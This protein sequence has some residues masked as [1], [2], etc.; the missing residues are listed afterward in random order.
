[1]NK[2]KA[3]TKRKTGEQSRTAGSLARCVSCITE[4]RILQLSNDLSEGIA[5][6]TVRDWRAVARYWRDKLDKAHNDINSIR[7]SVAAMVM[8]QN[9]VRFAHREMEEWLKR[10]SS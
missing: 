4:E 10:V 1:M 9:C 6:G 5:T 7:P 2:K 8:G 3:T